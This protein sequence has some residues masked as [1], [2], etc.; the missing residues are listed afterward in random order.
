MTPADPTTIQTSI[1]QAKKNYATAR[2]GVLRVH[3]RLAA[4]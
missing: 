1:N 3:M 2:T 4:L